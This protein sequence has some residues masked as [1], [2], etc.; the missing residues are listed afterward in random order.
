MAALI[1]A[2]CGGDDDDGTTRV[3]AAELRPN[4]QTLRLE[5][6]ACNTTEQVA[7][8]TESETEVRVTVT[9]RGGIEADCVDF[10]TVEL[11]ERLGQRPLIDDPTDTEIEVEPLPSDG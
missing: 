1:V 7:E 4:G 2:G 3:Y 10:M 6:G 9:T 5:L 11:T 8:V